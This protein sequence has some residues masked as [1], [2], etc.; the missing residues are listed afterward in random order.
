MGRKNKSEDKVKLGINAEVDT[1]LI[2]TSR[3]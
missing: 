1:I 3:V 2:F